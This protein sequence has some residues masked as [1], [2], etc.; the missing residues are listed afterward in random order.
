VGTLLDNKLEFDIYDSVDQLSIRMT[1][2]PFSIS[3]KTMVG[4]IKAW[5]LNSPPSYIGEGNVSITAI[6]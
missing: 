1:I 4:T 2:S 5:S 6:N 3:A